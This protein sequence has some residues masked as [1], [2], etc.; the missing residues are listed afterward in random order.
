MTQRAGELL[1]VFYEVQERVHDI[2]VATRSSEGVRL[3]FVNQ[4]ELEGMVIAGL[5]CLSNGVRNWLQ[6]VVQRRR[7]DDFALWP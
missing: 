3:R 7:F 4:I 2:N 6:L 5:C 1:L